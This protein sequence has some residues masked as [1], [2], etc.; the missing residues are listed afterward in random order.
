MVFPVPNGDKAELCNA[1]NKV[2]NLSQFCGEFNKSIE[3]LTLLEEQVK[4][5][6][7]KIFLNKKKL[8][9]FVN[10]AVHYFQLTESWN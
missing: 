8:R 10:Y 5:S 3:Y 4:D 7:Q 6:C 9:K 1:L 2:A